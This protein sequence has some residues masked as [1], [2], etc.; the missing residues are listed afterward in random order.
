MS[1]IVYSVW[2]FNDCPRSGI[3]SFKNSTCYFECEWDSNTDDYSKCYFLKQLSAEM[4]EMV[5]EYDDI[6]NEW[7]S[8]FESG[9]VSIE[10]HPANDGRNPR[11]LELQ[12]I[13]ESEIE[14]VPVFA[15]AVP[16]FSKFNDVENSSIYKNRQSQV[17]WKIV[18]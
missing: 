17:E 14:K 6:W 9:I 7:N 4:L 1:E 11:F 12:R 13:L 2:D 15:R 3:S 10:S 18:T 5:K 16:Q 8:K